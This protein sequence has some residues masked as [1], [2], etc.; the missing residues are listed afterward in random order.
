MA[1]VLKIILRNDIKLFDIHLEFTMK[2]VCTITLNSDGIIGPKDKGK[3]TLL[4]CIGAKLLKIPKHIDLL[5][6]E[7]EVVADET[8]AIQAVLNSDK[9]RVAYLKREKE[10]LEAQ[11]RGEKIDQ[12]ELKQLYEDMKAHGVDQAEPRSR[13][14]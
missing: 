9:K 10:L 4:R 11:D 14:I 2:T 6:C 8:P 7:Q 5:Y 12:D 1:N 3:T 13:R